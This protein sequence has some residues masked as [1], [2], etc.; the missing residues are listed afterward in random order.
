MITS[1][2]KQQFLRLAE[3]I[4]LTTDRVYFA[5]SPYKEITKFIKFKLVTPTA[6]E[7]LA[8]DTLE[9][10]KHA[11]LFPHIYGSGKH[12]GCLFTAH[13]NPDTAKITV[14]SIG[15]TPY[16]VVNPMALS[17]YPAFKGLKNK[18]WI[19]GEREFS[20]FIREEK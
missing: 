14:V 15:D 8:Y 2:N 3:N 17:E 4:N 20:D 19:D 12:T 9:N 16:Q 1:L 11:A 5:H 6:I 13:E 7:I 10:I 18:T